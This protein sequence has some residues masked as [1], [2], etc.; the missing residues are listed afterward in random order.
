M[1]VSRITGLALALL[2]G[3]GGAKA[4][5]EEKSASRKVKDE[6]VRTGLFRESELGY[7]TDALVKGA[8]RWGV[9][10]EV[11]DRQN[12]HFRALAW[13]GNHFLIREGW[14]YWQDDAPRSPCGVDRYRWLKYKPTG[15]ETVERSGACPDGTP[16]YTITLSET[17]PPPGS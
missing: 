10:V 3:V 13:Q 6:M 9:R 17:A 16:W 4:L 1:K 7:V 8:K 12:P 11:V 15:G 14:W 2:V 5:A